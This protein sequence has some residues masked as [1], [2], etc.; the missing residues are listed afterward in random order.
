MIIR[1]HYLE[2]IRE[3]LK[4]FP[5]VSVLGPRQVGKTTLAQA[6]AA[7]QPSH[8][9]DLEDVDALARLAE[10]KVTLE[11]LEDLVVLDEVQ[12]KPELFALLRVL[13]DRKPVKA[14]FL[15]TGSASPALVRGV[16]ESL[17]GRV[18]LVDVTGFGIQD[19]CIA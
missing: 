10:P 13:A 9:F 19:W 6:I 12:R 2:T 16:S 17:A 3:R 14:R 4:N 5:V 18:A 7:E 1:T 11:R 15:L 8:F